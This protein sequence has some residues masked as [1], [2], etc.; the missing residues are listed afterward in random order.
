MLGFIQAN[1]TTSPDRPGAF[2][3]GVWMS[4]RESNRTARGSR[5]GRRLLLVTLLA[6]TVVFAAG[7]LPG[8]G[9]SVRILTH[10]GFLHRG[11]ILD[12]EL[13]VERYHKPTP[14]F[15]YYTQI[16]TFEIADLRKISVN[17][18][19]IATIYSHGYDKG[20]EYTFVTKML[21]FRDAASGKEKDLPVSEI[22]LIEFGVD[23]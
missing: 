18:Q 19:G 16:G 1:A 8:S 11:V 17:S 6:A 5:P 4:H 9:T 13:K 22:R 3:G 12:K 15:V 14:G 10:G 21:R 2:R 23:S 20:T 7:C